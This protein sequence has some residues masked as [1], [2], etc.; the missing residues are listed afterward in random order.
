MSSSPE[1][2]ELLSFV[3][4]G[5]FVPPEFKDRLCQGDVFDEL[6]NTMP[7]AWLR[8]RLAAGVCGLTGSK[9]SPWLLLPTNRTSA[10]W[11][12]VH[13]CGDTDVGRCLAA[14]MALGKGNEERVAKSILEGAYGDVGELIPVLEKMSTCDTKA[15]VRGKLNKKQI[16]FIPEARISVLIK[17]AERLQRRC[18]ALLDRLYSH[19]SKSQTTDRPAET[20]QTAVRVEEHGDADEKPEVQRGQPP[21]SKTYPLKW[22]VIGVLIFLAAIVS[23]IVVIRAK[24]DMPAENTEFVNVW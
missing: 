23:S 20:L 24:K 16:P 22:I 4:S 14:S 2:T 3:D 12:L 1:A 5:Q 18:R 19:G 10:A 13:M 7:E 15:F 11:L 9:I 8:T 17:G 6:A 21:K